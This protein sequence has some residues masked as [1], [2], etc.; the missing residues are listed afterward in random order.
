[1]G[2]HGGG[3][4]GGGS[5]SSGG[6]RGG[7]SRGRGSSVRTST[8]P[9][10][11]CYNRSYYDRR[12]H[13]HRHYTSDVN[14]GMKSGWNHATIV[15]LIFMTC[16]LLLMTL[17]M[18]SASVHIGKK[19][20]GNSARIKIVDNA[21]LL[22]AREEEQTEELLQEVYEA[23]GMPVTVYTDNFDWKKHYTSLEVYSE[24][25]Y[26][27]MGMEEDAMIILF[28]A[29]TGADSFYDWEYDI[30]CGD[31]T[32]DCL[33]DAAFNTLLENFQKAMASQDL[34]QALEYAWNSVMDDLAKTTIE[35]IMLPVAIF[36]LIIY[37]I[38]YLP[39]VKNSNMAQDAYR[40]FQEHPDKYNTTP[41][42][43]YSECPSC[44]ASNASQSETCPYCGVLLK[45][46]D[47]D[48]RFVK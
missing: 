47:G 25:L 11:G 32:I 23:S 37:A 18:L 17:T 8:R 45:I 21:G 20:N 2:R 30:Y 13:F 43:L 46:S 39:I 31:D 7:G 24:E 1:M 3:S 12:G 35:W 10:R 15:L 26:Y 16:F 6:S 36:Y 42:L 44:G 34:Y 29:Q 33:S 48:V 9:F 28:T 5:H 22:T 38:I 27:Q 14:F 19:L 40:Y 41:M 4:R